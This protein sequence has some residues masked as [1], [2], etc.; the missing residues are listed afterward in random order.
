MQNKNRSQE[1][2]KHRKEEIQ[3]DSRERIRKEKILN[4]Y[5]DMKRPLK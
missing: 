2:N 1:R 3:R 4:S 5:G